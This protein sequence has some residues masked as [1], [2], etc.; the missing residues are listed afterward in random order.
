MFEDA[1]E[2]IKKSSIASS[3]FVGSDSIRHKKN[4]IWYAKYTTVIIIHIDSKHGAKVFSNTVDLLDY[5]NL[6]QRLMTEVQFAIEAATA[7]IDYVGDRSLSVHLDINSN[8]KHKSHIAVNEALG[9]VR[10]SL[11]IEADLKPGAWAATSCADHFVR[12]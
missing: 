6:K 12:H 11:G 5:G 1:I 9:W 2:A 3:I 7:I 10:G 4:D 8:P